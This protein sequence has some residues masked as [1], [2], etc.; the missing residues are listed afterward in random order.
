MIEKLS[1]YAHTAWSGWI[2]Y[3]F[4]KCVVNEDGSLTI[5]KWAV[6][7]WTRQ[8]TTPYAKL[9]LQEK[10]SDKHEA[11]TILTLL[12]IIID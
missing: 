2:Q 9:P 5:P 12:D 1:E 11:R 6:E 10:E 8:A 4:S 7:R 3:M